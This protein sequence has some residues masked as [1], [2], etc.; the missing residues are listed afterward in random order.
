MSNESKDVA[1]DGE[2]S[3]RP[4]C[5]QCGKPATERIALEPY[6]YSWDDDYGDWDT[7]TP[8]Q[9]DDVH[10]QFLCDDCEGVDYVWED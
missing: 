7:S 9:G 3:T 6:T 2:E 1:E 5:D 4:K 10:E 8:K